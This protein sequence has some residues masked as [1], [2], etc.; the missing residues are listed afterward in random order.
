MR[1][2]INDLRI[3][4]VV[5]LF[6]EKLHYCG[7]VAYRDDTVDDTLHIFWGWNKWKKRRYYEVKRE[8]ELHLDWQYLRRT[9][10]RKIHHK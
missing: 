6:G 4:D 3:V 7:C 5:Y 9:K 10:K 1:G 8:W 2:T